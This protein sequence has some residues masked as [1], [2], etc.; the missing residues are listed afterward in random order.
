MADSEREKER[1]RELRRRFFASFDQMD[2]TARDA[3][4]HG[5]SAIRIDLSA[6]PTTEGAEP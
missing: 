1:Q 5:N 3:W 6:P 4:L 2:A